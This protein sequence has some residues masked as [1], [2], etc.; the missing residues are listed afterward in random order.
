[1]TQPT[2]SVRSGPGQ[3]WPPICSSA[4]RSRPVQRVKRDAAAIVREPRESV[5]G[6][7]V[8]LY[9]RL[10]NPIIAEGQICSQVVSLP[11]EQPDCQPRFGVDPHAETDLVV[12]CVENAL[13]GAR[14]HREYVS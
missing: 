2:A 3:G 14:V 4:C 10:G 8:S 9:M 6:P 7:S 1:M 5:A 11:V 12:A 13:Q